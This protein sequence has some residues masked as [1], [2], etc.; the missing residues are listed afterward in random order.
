[1]NISFAIANAVTDTRRQIAMISENR[2]QI[3]IM[4]RWEQGADTAQIAH[5]LRLHEAAVYAIT[6]ARR[7]RVAND[8]GKV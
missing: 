5:E 4:R 1:M 6:S 3:L 7:A 8:G 2:S